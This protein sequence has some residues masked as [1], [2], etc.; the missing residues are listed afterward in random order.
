M[1]ATIIAPKIDST[2][3]SVRPQGYED[4]DLPSD[5]RELLL[6]HE[7]KK[8]LEKLRVQHSNAQRL[9][10][11]LYQ[12]RKEKFSSITNSVFSTFI[13]SAG[14]W[15]A[16]GGRYAEE[17]FGGYYIHAGLSLAVVGIVFGVAKPPLEALIWKL[18]YHHKSELL[19]PHCSGL[20]VNKD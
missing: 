1:S 12:L 9:L 11:E 8:E 2:S 15:L 17:L 16:A 19:C 4:L 13:V 6:Y 14:S 20:V 18:F 10:R 5:K 7:S 3:S